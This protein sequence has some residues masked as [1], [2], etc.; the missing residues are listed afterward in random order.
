MLVYSKSYNKFLN[1]LYSSV[2]EIFINEMNISYA[3]T[4]FLYNNFHYPLEIVLYEG[5][6]TLGYFEAKRFRI[7][8]NKNFI[9]LNNNNFLLNTLRHEL[10]HY[11]DFIENGLS[12]LPHGQSFKEICSRFNWNEDVFRAKEKFNFNS[13]E[14]PSKV[15]DKISK[16]LSLATS[17]N[18]HEA[19]SA[20]KKANQLLINNQLNLNH[21]SSDEKIIYVQKVL[22]QKIITP[23]FMAID[24]ILTFYFVKTVISKIK[25][26]VYLEVLGDK[27]NVEIAN[28]IAKYLDL[29][30]EL[31]WTKQKKELQ[32]LT[33]S[34]KR[35]FMKGIEEGFA[36]QIQTFQNKSVSSTML[37]TVQKS[38]SE[39]FKFVYPKLSSFRLKNNNL[40][41]NTKKLGF[42][43]GKNLKMKKGIS[44]GLSKTIKRLTLFQN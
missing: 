19:Q 9:N 41:K 42:S 29:E 28:Y 21:I 38:L 37:I 2:R 24:K 20:L 31:L 15:S 40:D 35:S 8:I 10:A 18:P 1:L 4:R 13:F 5:E 22:E 39:Q 6:R 34:S 11:I 44:K 12:N 27:S 17:D 36:S 16:L 14:K 23:K 3:R 33:T 7:G 32:K 30:L 43:I 25:G 26:G